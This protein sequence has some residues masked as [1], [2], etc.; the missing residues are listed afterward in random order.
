MY[1]VWGSAGNLSKGRRPGGG[2]RNLPPPCK[3]R[4]GVDTPLPLLLLGFL[5]PKIL[6]ECRHLGLAGCGSDPR[7]GGIVAEEGIGGR[8]GNANASKCKPIGSENDA[9]TGDVD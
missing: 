5:T 9:G 6:N 1:G 3:T 7:K 8:G 4:G 2:G